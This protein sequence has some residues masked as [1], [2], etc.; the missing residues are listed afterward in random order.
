MV[1]RVSDLKKQKA[2][3]LGGKT[4]LAKYGRNYLRELGKRGGR[5]KLPTLQELQKQQA[6]ANQGKAWGDISPEDL[7]NSLEELKS[8]WKKRKQSE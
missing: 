4:T 3:H 1:A 5:P 8:L 7:P 2:G 6:L